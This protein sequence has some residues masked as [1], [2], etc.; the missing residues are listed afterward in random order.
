MLTNSAY[1]VDESRFS[2]NNNNQ[3][4]HRV[5][6]LGIGETVDGIVYLREVRVL[7]ILLKSYAIVK[8]VY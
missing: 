2:S 3:V 8:E 7:G 4:S 6:M 5:V 1:L